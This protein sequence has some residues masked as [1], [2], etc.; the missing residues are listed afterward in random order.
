MNS[1]NRTNCAPAAAALSAYVAAC[2][3]FPS[4]SWSSDFIWTTAIR[5]DL[6][7]DLDVVSRSGLWPFSG[8]SIPADPSNRRTTTYKDIFIAYD[9][10]QHA[11]HQQ[12]GNALSLSQ[13]KRTR[14]PA[15]CKHTQGFH[16]HEPSG[17]I[18]TVRAKPRF[19]N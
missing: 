4:M 2:L 5:K 3:R 17:A 13:H 10:P 14:V 19:S 7:R 9:L 11:F 18:G 1:G 16:S 6:G 8:I 15:S 12:H